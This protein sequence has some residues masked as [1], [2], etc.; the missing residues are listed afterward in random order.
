MKMRDNYL[1][2]IKTLVDKDFLILFFKKVYQKAKEN[3]IFTKAMAMVYITMLSIIPFFIFSF[4]I[5]TLFNFFGKMDNIINELKNLIINNLAAGPGEELID[6]LEIYILNVNLEQLGIISFISLIFIIVFMLAKVEI[7]FNKIWNVK[8]H[9]DLFK[10]FVS[11]W[12]FITLGTFT[13]TL[14]LTL[15]LLFAEK[16]FGLWLNNSQLSQNSFISHILFSFNFLIFITAYY[17][18]PNTDVNAFSAAAAGI[19]S[20]TL[21]VLLKNLYGIYTSNI[22][23][24]G[25]LY[26]PL[27]IIPIFLLW[28][29]LIWIIILLGAVIS[30]VIQ[31]FSSLECSPKR[32]KSVSALKEFIPA[33][34]L[35]TIYKAFRQQDSTPLTAAEL[36]ARIKISAL[37]LDSA[38]KKLQEKNLIAKTENE[39]YLPLNQAGK[40]SLWT[41]YKI[42]HLSQEDEIKEIFKD[43][44]MQ[45]LVK[46][47]NCCQKNNFS[48]LKFSDFL[49]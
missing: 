11:F 19:F 44:E 7:T 21:F 40:L 33:A 23:S 46:K 3:E 43:K 20:G 29:Y 4:Y 25:Q 45:Q 22:V 38:L 16:Y 9:R 47:L 5:M 13:V 30:Y 48:Q 24:Y 35:I 8:E 12:T 26:G 17:F 18:I 1:T 49:K 42:N 31:H 10:R 41:V 36:L 6:Y 34:V 14:F 39:T 15:S 32:K 37:D 28:L 27:S 2:K